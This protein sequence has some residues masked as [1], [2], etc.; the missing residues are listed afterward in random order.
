[1]KKIYVWILLVALLVMTAG[2]NRNPDEDIY[3]TNNVTETISQEVS[4]ESELPTEAESQSLEAEDTTAAP[5]EDT[6]TVSEEVYE[7]DGSA[8]ETV[9]EGDVD[10]SPVASTIDDPEFEASVL[11]FLDPVYYNLFFGYG[12]YVDGLTEE[13]MTKFAI[14]YIYQHEYNELKFDTTDFILYVPEKRVEEIVYKYFDYEVTGHHSFIEDNL[15]YEDS[16]YLMP[17][18]DAGWNDVMS[19][20]SVSTTGDFSYDVIFDVTNEM[21]GSIVTYKAGIEVR[22]DRYVLVSYLVIESDETVSEESTS[23]E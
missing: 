23:S 20:K 9:N 18:V 8:T 4:T 15:M 5:E 22:N 6:T 10:T 14:S 2:C 11:A 16:F 21:D 12:N 13:D 7:N 19:I 1:M 17:A 3:G